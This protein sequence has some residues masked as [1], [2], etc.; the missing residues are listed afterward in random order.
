MTTTYDK[1]NNG[2]AFWGKMNGV[3]HVFR[4]LRGSIFVA[5]NWEGEI[6]LEKIDFIELIPKP[7]SK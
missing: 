5:E 6:A 7:T 3:L 1:I 4:K 2:D